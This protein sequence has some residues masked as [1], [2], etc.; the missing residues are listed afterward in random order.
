MTQH[1]LRC[2]I[3]WLGEDPALEREL[4]LEHRSLKSWEGDDDDDDDD[5]DNDD[6]DDDNDDNDDN[7]DDDDD[8]EDDG[9]G[10][11]VKKTAW[12]ESAELIWKA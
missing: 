1:M 11:E 2:I 7:D 4:E 10:D 3:Q 5:N 9:D 8:D 6:N 12:N